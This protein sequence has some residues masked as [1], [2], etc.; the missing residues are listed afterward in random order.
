[1]PVM[2]RQWVLTVCVRRCCDRPD[3]DEKELRSNCWIALCQ[4]I[5]CAHDQDV[6]LL[7]SFASVV[8]QLMEASLTHPVRSAT[9][10]SGARY[11][12]LAR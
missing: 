11:Q 10:L 7:V 9:Q 1:V 2:S 3:W 5:R 4:L 6:P 8:V 12:S